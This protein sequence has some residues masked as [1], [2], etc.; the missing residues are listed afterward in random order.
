MKNVFGKDISLT[1]IKKI[2]AKFKNTGEVANQKRSK[3]KTA[4][5]PSN[6]N[7]V[8]KELKKKTRNSSPKRTPFRLAQK[9]N[10]S[11]SSVS[12]ILKYDLGARAYKRH[13]VHKLNEKNKMDRLQRCKWLLRNITNEDAKNV[14]FTDESVFPISGYHNAQNERIYAVNK[15]DIS[16]EEMLKERQQFPKS[17]MVWMG[18]STKGKTDVIVCEEGCKITAETYKEGILQNALPQA[19][20]MHRGKLIWQQDSAPSHKAKST[21]SYLKKSVHRLIPADRWPPCSPDLNPMD[22]CVWGMLKQRVYARHFTTTDELAGIIKEEA[23]LLDQ[24]KITSS[25]EQW[26]KRMQLVVRNN[27][28]HIEHQL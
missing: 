16:P 19:K 17:V 27:G 18:V 23:K 4:R 6:I 12:R 9:L 1:G 22:Y 21:Q 14:L 25:I 13:I 2:I 11:K 28:G 8:K 15:A 3:K 24:G 10:I 5:T 26:R 7:Q 20:K